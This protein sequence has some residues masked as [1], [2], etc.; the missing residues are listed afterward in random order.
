MPPY[1]SVEVRYTT[2][3]GTRCPTLY[4]ESVGSLTSHRFLLYVQGLVRRG[5]R[6][7]VL[8]REDQKVK[9]FADV[10]T[11][12]ALSPQLFKDPECWSGRGLNLRPPAQQTGA[13]P[14][15]LSGRRLFKFFISE[16]D[17]AKE[18]INHDLLN[19]IFAG[20]AMITRVDLL[21]GF[22]TR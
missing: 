21:A 16:Q 20:L 3:S 1:M 9:P 7:I 18:S 14:I 5:L 15:E 8:I 17:S 12:A 19:T 4:E 11:K 13:C 6:F 10:I 22:S 2:T